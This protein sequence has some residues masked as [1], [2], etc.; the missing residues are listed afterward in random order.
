[1]AQLGRYS[2]EGES[3]EAT[4]G[5]FVKGYTYWAALIKLV[6]LAPK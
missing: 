1:L 6:L 4:K 2:A 3:E 5:M